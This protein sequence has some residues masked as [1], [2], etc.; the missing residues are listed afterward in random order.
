[1]KREKVKHM[2]VKGGASL[3]ALRI[4]VTC[5]AAAAW[6]ECL[7]SVFPGMVVSRSW[8]YG[9]GLVLAVIIGGAVSCPRRKV[10]VPAVILAAALLCWRFF[11]VIQGAAAHLVNAY[12][13]VHQ[14]RGFEV[15]FWEEGSLSAGT[16]AVGTAVLVCVPLL[17][18]LLL[19]I[20]W[21]RG[22]L[23]AVLILLLPVLAAILEGA[24]PSAW[25]TWMLIV[26][27]GC[28]LTAAGAGGRDMA[29]PAGAAW[30]GTAIAAVTL[31]VLGGVS[32]LA[33]RAAD[34]I[35]LEEDGFYSQTR[36]A[37]QTGVVDNL[38]AVR[39]RME[40]QDEEADD[41]PEEEEQL[42]REREEDRAE[43]AA[44]EAPSASDE[45]SETPGDS[46][47][48]TLPWDT[49]ADGMTDL[50]SVARFSPDGTAAE[51]VRLEEAPY[52]TVYYPLRWGGA[53]TGQSWEE[54]S[55]EDGRDSLFLSWPEGLD[56]LEE[57][58]ASW[59]SDTVEEAEKQIDRELT[60]KAVYDTE[61]GRTPTGEDFAEYFVFESE[62]GFCVHFATAAVLMYRM[63]GYPARYVEGYAVPA[64][65]FS[66]QADGTYL[67]VAD[68]T[69]G[70]AWCETFEDGEWTVREHTPA[71]DGSA[72]PGSETQTASDSA[73]RHGQAGDQE[74]AGPGAMRIAG[75]AALLL[76]IVGCVIGAFFL[77][78]AVRRKRRLR[79][80]GGR[81]RTKAVEAIYGT[82]YDRSR[83]MG[84]KE[85]SP[86]RE[87][88]CRRM[89]DMWDSIKEQEMR[90][91]YQLVLES[92]F[93]EKRPSAREYRKA[94]DIY[95]KTGAEMYSRLRG[96]QR[97]KYKYIWCL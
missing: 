80:L 83:T 56:R 57:L 25:A 38:N 71:S 54:T 11:Y 69:M 75:R 23:V 28:Y 2:S 32:V 74:K 21:G 85:S 8:L 10:A 55:G 58:C 97:W 88:T 37:I 76:A 30:A 46:G 31:L 27:G 35:R 33:G 6:W 79:V 13:A 61:P 49:E 5:L 89:A 65:A 90:W 16:L 70:H 43:V 4:F 63:M 34:V 17:T 52:G 7:F 72:S 24:F 19:V 3:F 42:P 44:K 14:E 59:P 81:N 20:R 51:D 93:N 84:M 78:A 9:A 18:I 67:A 41:R 53:Y 96:W 36:Q 15:R 45:Q 92:M 48:G 82:I 40:G 50:A 62:R 95:R 68:G 77:Q 12:L 60:Q 64:S 1:M 22:K 87:E 47:A 29:G 86:L 39:L 94:M 26:T 66:R 91:L 73:L